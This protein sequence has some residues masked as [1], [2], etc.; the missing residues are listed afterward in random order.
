MPYAYDCHL[1]GGSSKPDDHNYSYTDVLK[2]NFT[3]QAKS[4]DRPKRDR[5]EQYRPQG[6]E[7]DKA[8]TFDH[9]SHTDDTKT[10][11][12]HINS[13]K[14]TVSRRDMTRMEK[15]E[16]PRYPRDLDIGRILIEEISDQKEEV[17]QGDVFKR[18]EVKPRSEKMETSYEI[19]RRPKSQLKEETIKVGKLDVT[20]YDRTSRVSDRLEERM[21]TSTGRIPKYLEV[22]C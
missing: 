20:D 7:F 4:D 1:K 19:E 6:A 9:K 2:L 15:T 10:S 5:T 22:I 16:K 14:I 13:E 3:L 11:Q 8:Y 17:T 12:K 21:T 18:D